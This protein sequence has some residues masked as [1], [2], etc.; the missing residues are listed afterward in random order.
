M[1]LYTMFSRNS[2]ALKQ[3]GISLFTSRTFILGAFFSSIAFT[4][5]A[6]AV[7][8]TNGETAFDSPPALIDSASNSLAFDG[9]TTYY[10]TVKVP[11]N[12][13]EPL[14]TLQI[15]Q[16]DNLGTVEFVANQSRAYFGS[17]LSMASTIPLAS[18]GGTAPPRGET[19]VVFD[20]PIAAGKTVTIALQV[21]TNPAYAGGIYLFGVTA[22][23]EG[24]SS[25]GQFL[26]FGRLQFYGH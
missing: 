24:E 17:D 3:S 16:A 15:K 12:A 4:L 22:F 21:K 10:F 9:A 18:I 6:N 20:Q 23:P 19:T 13:G 8:L 26:G 2:E 11:E 14:K 7:K 5:P 1:E 25:R